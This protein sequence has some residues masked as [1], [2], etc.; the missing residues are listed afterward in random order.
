MLTPSRGAF[1]ASFFL[2]T[3]LAVASMNPAASAEQPKQAT[4][5]ATTLRSADL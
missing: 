3:A 2:A 4:P 1:A 5:S